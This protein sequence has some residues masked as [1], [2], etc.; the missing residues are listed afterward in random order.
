LEEARNRAAAAGERRVGARANLDQ[1]TAARGAAINGVR[2]AGRALDEHNKRLRGLTDARLRVERRR[3]NLGTEIESLQTRVAELG[4]RV[5][6][7]QARVAELEALLP[8][9]EGE[10]DETLRR[11]RAMAEARSQLE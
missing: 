7:E 10:E 3:E 11:G 9:L 6:R 4:E 5:T 1:A 2:D 8:V